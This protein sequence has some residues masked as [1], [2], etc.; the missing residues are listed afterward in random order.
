MLVYSHAVTLLKFRLCVWLLKLKG[1]DTDL[2]TTSTQ[3]KVGRC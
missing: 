2:A 1:S 3:A